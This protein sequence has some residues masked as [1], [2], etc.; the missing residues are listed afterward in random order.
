MGSA[1]VSCRCSAGREVK[2][3]GERRCSRSGGGEVGQQ[4]P[5]V[6]RPWS[7]TIRYLDLFTRRAVRGVAL[8]H[9]PLN[10][11]GR[12]VRSQIAKFVDVVLGRPSIGRGAPFKRQNVL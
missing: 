5:F 10:G 2:T 6:S 9:H 7:F 3:F 1:V 11:V 4:S 12:S 8:L